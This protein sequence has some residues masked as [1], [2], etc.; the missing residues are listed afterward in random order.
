MLASMRYKDFIWPHNPRVYSIDFER[1]VAVHKVPAGMYFMQ[2]MGRCNRVIKGDGEFVGADAYTQFGKLASVFYSDG[3]GQLIHPVWQT[4]NA[5]FVRLS[6]KQE[7]RAN[8]VA[9]SFEFWESYDS[10]TPGAVQVVWT[11]TAVENSA[12]TEQY[13]TVVR[14]DNLW[15]ICQSYGVSLETVLSLNTWIKN[16]NLIYAGERIRVA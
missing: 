2:D 8:Y 10:Y 9:Y 3:P 12:G 14:G 6:L 16:P 11:S 5:Y 13:H 4:S 15:S 7:P 1:R